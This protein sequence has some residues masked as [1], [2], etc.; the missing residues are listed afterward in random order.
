MPYEEI[1]SIAYST[2]AF[3]FNSFCL[4]RLNKPVGPLVHR[5]TLTDGPDESLGAAYSSLLHRV[6]RI[7]AASGCSITG[8]IEELLII[9]GTVNNCN[10]TS[11]LVD[12]GATSNFIDGEWIRATG[13]A[14]SRLPVSLNVCLADGQR[15]VCSEFVKAAQLCVDGYDGTH[16]FIVMPSLDGCVAVLGMKFLVQS[17]CVVDFES[18][19]MSFKSAVKPLPV[20]QRKVKVAKVT[21]CRIVTI[22]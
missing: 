1:V 4:I 18:R 12:S 11:I 21:G 17:R 6:G 14:I 16:D 9:P 7:G 19:V 5:G 8:M 20:R 15:V 2:S 22:H 3:C 10:A 13:V